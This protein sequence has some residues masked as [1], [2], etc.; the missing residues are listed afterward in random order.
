MATTAFLPKEHKLWKY[1]D[2]GMHKVCFDN[3]EHKEEFQELYR[4]ML[5]VDFDDPYLKE[6]VEKYG[7]PDWLKKLEEC[8]ENK[9]K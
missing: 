2:T 4:Y 9:L 7:M 6:M 5:T 3:W 1:S 8:Q